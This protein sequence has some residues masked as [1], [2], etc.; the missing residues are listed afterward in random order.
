MCRIKA[1][2]HMK[3]LHSTLFHFVSSCF[4]PSRGHTP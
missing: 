4:V 1:S 3:S 2:H